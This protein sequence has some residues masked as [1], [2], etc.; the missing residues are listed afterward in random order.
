[1]VHAVE[2]AVII[3]L[4]VAPSDARHQ[5]NA[6]APV[7]PGLNAVGHRLIDTVYDGHVGPAVDSVAVRL[8]SL[9]YRPLQLLT[10][11]DL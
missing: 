2:P 1:M 8:V 6:I 9:K 4:I 5:V 3:I 7:S 10:W 11:V